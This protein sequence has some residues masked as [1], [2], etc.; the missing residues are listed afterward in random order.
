MTWTATNLLIQ[1]ITGFLGGHI[2]A[3][4]AKEHEFGALGHTITGLIGGAVSGY[5]LQTVVATV[6]NG[7]GDAQ[8]IDAPTQWMLQGMA[9]LVAGAI[10][11]MAIGLLK[12]GIEHHRGQKALGPAE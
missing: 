11:T 9:G 8:P 2:A 5:F 12:H 7:V 4:V 6:V 10:V 1:V 3:M